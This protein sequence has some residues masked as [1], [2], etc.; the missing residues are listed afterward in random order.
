MICLH[1]WTG[2][3]RSLEFV[4][5][6]PIDDVSALVQVSARCRIG[7]EPGSE[8]KIACLLTQIYIN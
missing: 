6:C 2:N 3:N 5:M 1:F 4:L 8:A 7:D